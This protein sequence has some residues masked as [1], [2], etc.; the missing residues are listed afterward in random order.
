MLDAIV[1]IQLVVTA[2]AV[3]AAFTH[4]IYETSTN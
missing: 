3:V 1:E 4:Y 2:I